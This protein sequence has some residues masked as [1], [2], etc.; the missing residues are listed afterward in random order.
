MGFIV[1]NDGVRSIDFLD[2]SG[3]NIK[4][5]LGLDKEDNSKL[6][7]VENGKSIFKVTANKDGKRI[8]EMRDNNGTL[9][10]KLMLDEKDR[11]LFSLSDGDGE[12]H[13]LLREEPANKGG[14]LLKAEPGFFKIP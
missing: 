8:L 9:R 11:P 14:I 1:D 12:V 2:K 6:D 4:I 5:R 7:F 3:E 10:T 13:L